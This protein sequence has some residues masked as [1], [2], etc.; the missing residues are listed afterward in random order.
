MYPKPSWYKRAAVTPRRLAITG[1]IALS[2]RI[3]NASNFFLVTECTIIF[4]G[5]ATLL[6]FVLPAV[7]FGPLRDYTV[8]K[9]TGK[10]GFLGR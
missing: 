3:T 1:L 5:S 7:A 6:S 10:T 9:F 2:A 8:E 4:I